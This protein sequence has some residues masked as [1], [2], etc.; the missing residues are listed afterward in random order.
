MYIN[1][2]KE[3]FDVAKGDLQELTELCVKLIDII[4][5]LRHADLYLPKNRK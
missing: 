5:G 4:E 3:R 2:I 1:E